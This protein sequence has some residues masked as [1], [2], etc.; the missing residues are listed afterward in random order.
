[1]LLAVTHLLGIAANNSPQTVDIIRGRRDGPIVEY[2]FSSLMFKEKVHSNEYLCE[3]VTQIP[4]FQ[5]CQT[6]TLLVFTQGTSCKVTV[7]ITFS[8][9][10]D[11]ADTSHKQLVCLSMLSMAA[12]SDNQEC[13]ANDDTKVTLR[14]SDTE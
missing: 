13:F 10:H 8:S 12:C 7:A 6:Q 4:S 9:N 5:M 14:Q 2:L 11:A 1:M 3:L